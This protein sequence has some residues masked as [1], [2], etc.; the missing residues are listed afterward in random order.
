MN[1]LK[2]LQNVRKKP[3]APVST[4]C[5]SESQDNPAHGAVHGA[6]PREDCD[7]AHH[8]L[9]EPKGPDVDSG[10]QKG[11]RVCMGSGVPEMATP[12]ASQSSQ[13]DGD[14]EA[15]GRIISE[16]IRR[17]CD[18]SRELGMAVRAGQTVRQFGYRRIQSFQRFKHKK[19]QS[20]KETLEVVRT[21][22]NPNWYT[23]ST[24][25]AR[26]LESSWYPGLRTT[27]RD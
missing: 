5:N 18:Q 2:V 23:I 3:V 10:T 22:V 4:E 9:G 20:P 12:K 25:P 26:P 1:L 11:C 7:G 8:H 27:F 21:T 19:V 17:I 15:E 24:E 16:C 13:G 6:G 14:T